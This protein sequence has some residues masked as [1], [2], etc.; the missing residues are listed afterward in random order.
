MKKKLIALTVAAFSV[1]STPLMAWTEGDF[2]GNLEFGGPVTP[3]DITWK[4]LLSPALTD[5]NVDFKNMT[6]ESDGKSFSA[7]NLFES[8]VVMLMGKTTGKSVKPVAGLSPVINFGDVNTV[9]KAGLT[10]NTK[11][12]TL[13]VM[14]DTLGKIGFL[15]FDF[16][17]MGIIY[18]RSSAENRH[19][20]AGLATPREDYGNGY[21]VY[22]SHYDTI[23]ND[24][25]KTA[26]TQALDGEAPDLSG[27]TS[28][29][30]GV[31]HPAGFSDASSVYTNLGGAYAAILK[32]KSGKLRIYSDKIPTSGNWSAK[33]P[34]TVSYR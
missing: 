24:G 15:S 20:Y 19:V 3:E 22:K 25:F 8:P 14:H 27:F 9:A 33:L 7:T 10:Q 17:P 18:G 4:W 13:D 6:A 11:G 16:S 29:L 2:N 34:V 32:E 12:I 5:M 28:A 23:G 31:S 26:I 1:I 30:G 21:Y